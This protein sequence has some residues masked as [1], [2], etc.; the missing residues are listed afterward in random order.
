ML[1]TPLHAWP[2]VYKGPWRHLK[3]PVFKIS[4]KTTFLFEWKLFSIGVEMGFKYIV[5]MLSN[6]AT[7]AGWKTWRQ[8]RE[9]QFT[10]KAG[11]AQLV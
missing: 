8:V 4:N 11:D 7:R 1:F 6:P 9:R 5:Y 2:N 10:E 3:K